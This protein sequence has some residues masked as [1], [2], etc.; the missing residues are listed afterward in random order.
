LVSD[1]PPQYDNDFSENGHIDAM[2]NVCIDRHDETVNMVFLDWGVRS[3]G[4]KELWELKWSRNWI[5]DY[6][7]AGRP[8]EWNDPDH[9]MYNMKDY[10]LIRMLD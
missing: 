1:V 9:W 8:T 10:E 7:E 4:L 6:R 3:V 2:K 5:E